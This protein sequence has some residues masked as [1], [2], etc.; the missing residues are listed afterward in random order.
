[1]R[2]S[3][4]K[5]GLVF[6]GLK[7]RLAGLASRAGVSGVAKRSVVAAALVGLVLA[8][9]AGYRWFAPVR[10]TETFG[11]AALGSAETSSTPGEMRADA[12]SSSVSSSV[13][14]SAPPPAFVHIVGAVVHP[15]VYEVA[16][17]ARLGDVVTLA[18]GFTGNAAQASVNLAR[19]VADGE[20]VV[21][22][23]TDEI[24]AA[25]APPSAASARAPT[26]VPSAATA[27]PTAP[28]GGA[29]APAPPALPAPSPPG[30]EAPTGGLVNVNS[31]GAAELET[32]PGI[33]PATAAAIID[34]R[35][36]NGP[37]A[38]VDDL[39]RVTGIG[40]KKLAAI[41]DLVC[42]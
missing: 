34:E 41:R 37:F 11:S 23:T 15:G 2:V 33:G 30:E 35:E 4:W 38:T 16:G 39:I 7:G 9:W 1:V 24:A 14:A 25:A 13:E 42:V 32:L 19:L 10:S 20:Q 17:D 40:E 5:W 12:S 6:D 26:P 31:A 21:V 28:S 29:A 3:R 22:L 36:Q 18:G 27:Q 8:G